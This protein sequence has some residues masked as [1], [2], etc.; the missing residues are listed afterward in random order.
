MR[1]PLFLSGNKKAQ[2]K[3]IVCAFFLAVPDLLPANQAVILLA[4]TQDGETPKQ[5]FAI[6]DLM[7]ECLGLVAVNADATALDE[8]AG[9]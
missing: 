1:F 7:V 2:T 4:T 3:Q 9:F 6:R 5:A 8:A